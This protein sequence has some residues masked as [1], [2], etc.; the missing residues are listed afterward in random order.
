[1]RTL[2]AGEIEA[3]GKKKTLSNSAR[4]AL[5]KILMAKMGFHLS[6]TP[7]ASAKAQKEIEFL[8]PIKNI[9]WRMMGKNQKY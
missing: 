5:Q 6:T 7:K 1:L 9:G 4:S 2:T 3:L 8:V